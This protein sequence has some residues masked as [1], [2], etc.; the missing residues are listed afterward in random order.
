MIQMRQSNAL[1]G[2]AS[3]LLTQI[4]RPLGAAATQK[5]AK[6]AQ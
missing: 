4:Q 5:S 6:S 1:L 3:G 2:A